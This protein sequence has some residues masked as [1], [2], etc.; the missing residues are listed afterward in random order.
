MVVSQGHLRAL[1]YEMLCVLKNDNY[2]RFEEINYTIYSSSL[3]RNSVDDLTLYDLL[4]RMKV[5]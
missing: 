3:C 2:M 5:G 1:G 4:R